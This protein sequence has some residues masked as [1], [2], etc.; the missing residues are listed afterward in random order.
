M[1]YLPYGY[2]GPLPK[3][4]GDAWDEENRDSL[5]EAD[6]Q[7]IGSPGIKMLFIIY[8]YHLLL[9]LLYCIFLYYF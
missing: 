2:N 6:H 9:L 4:S 8:H 3:S 7:H 1:S 5:P